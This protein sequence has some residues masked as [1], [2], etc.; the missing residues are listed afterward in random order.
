MR[1][2]VSLVLAA[3]L[4]LV[5]ACESADDLKVAS[6]WPPADSSGIALDSRI[7]VGY[8]RPVQLRT[9]TMGLT[10]NLD[11][12][13]LAG[14][15][16]VDEGGGPLIFTPQHMLLP[17]R[18][19]TVVL[20]REAVQDLAGHS[21]S[22]DW[23][24]SF[25][26]V[27]GCQVN[28]AMPAD[29]P[30]GPLA[31][32]GTLI[33][34]ARRISPAGQTLLAGSFPM[35]LLAWPDRPLA[36]V[37]NNGKGLGAGRAQSLQLFDLDEPELLQTIERN[38]PGALF[39]GLALKADGSR[40]Y[41]AG[42]GA[43]Q[44]EYFDLAADGRSLDKVGAYPVSGYPSGLLLDE[45]R[46]RLYVAAQLDG[47]L[48]AIDLV[49]G[50]PLWSRRIGMLPYDLV[51]SADRSKLY[52][53]LWARVEL[54]LPG[55]VAVVDPTNGQVLSKIEV[56]KNP[57][58]MTLGSDGRLYVACSDADRVDVI[59][60]QTDALLASWSLLEGPNAKL[61]LSPTS[62][63]LDESMNRLYV[64]CAQ[65]NSID[66]LDLRDGSLLGSLP[67]AWYPTGVE[68]RA[69]G[70]LLV[71]T[72]KGFGSGPNPNRGS[73]HS[74]M[75][76]SLSIIDPPS[77]ADL[78]AGA[79]TVR[80]NNT[81][82]LT[83]YPERCLGKAFPIPRALGQASP[84]KHVIFVLRENKTYD[85]NLGDLEDSDG[86]PSLV[87][88]GE[89]TTP[90]LHALAREFCNLDN[91][92]TEI[93][94]SVQGHYWN[95]AATINDYSERIM[96]ANYRDDSRLPS[97][98]TQQPDYPAGSFIWQNL[99]A[100]GIDF[101]NYGEPMGILGDIHLFEDKINKDYMLDLGLSLYSTPDATR[102]EWFMEELEA[103]IYPPFIY[104][105]LLND[106]T[107]GSS[108]GQPTA[109]WMVAENDYAT[110]LL[111]DRISH[112]EHW[113]D[114]LI[115]VTE[116]DPQSGADHVDGHRSIALL[117]SPFSRRGYTSS[118][119]YGFSSLIRTYGLILGMPALNLLDE[120]APPIYDC[121]TSEPDLTP[122][123][124]RP[125]QIDYQL[126]DLRTP[127]AL[128][129]MAMDFTRPDRADGLGEVLWKATRPH[130]AIPPQL[131]DAEPWPEREE[132]EER[133]PLVVPVQWPPHDP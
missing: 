98:G 41:V 47:S 58:D 117:I 31:D 116:D 36:A 9:G 67:T 32:G 118:V 100:A 49:S 38:R 95:T 15:L 13:P 86:D 107:Y 84:I 66:A 97:T 102:V 33:P 24:W 126:N 71:S 28:P 82:G 43:D 91:F 119:H 35:N 46:N 2:P 133:W 4:S 90:N 127:G 73:I 111:V 132:Q 81:Y 120:F 109:Q 44:V 68:V 21:L 27:E 87:M 64:A 104:L 79:S 52:I 55:H 40:L 99:T 48:A 128:E 14:D 29:A 37:T 105:A 45:T 25:S 11:G 121:F 18:T 112:S 129:S 130:D 50:E 114:T 70:R 62:L 75:R 74:T 10:L 94:V 113:H 61:G 12:K 6:V 30:T 17:G 93:E 108:P 122:Y 34:G 60:T 65:K 88:F 57:Q 51:M 26:T 56:G 8:Q 101:R 5:S 85:Q 125:M 7:E 78:R 59:D 110:G 54:G 20:S 23:S 83:F 103:G 76:G 72:G 96:H 77:D 53:S 63:S 123:D 22:A 131:L 3:L 92:Y 42:G 69:D 106:H 39:Y 124:V 19:Y 1:V 115:I 80:D 16:S 89:Q